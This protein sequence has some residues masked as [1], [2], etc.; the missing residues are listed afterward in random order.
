MAKILTELSLKIS[1]DVAELRTK[2]AQVN[3]SLTSLQSTTASMGDK[4]MSTFKA[5][6]GAMVAAFAVQKLISFGEECMRL[7]AKVEGVQNAFVKMGGSTKILDDLKAATRGALDDSDLMAFAVKANSFHIPMSVLVTDLTVATAQAIKLGKPIKDFAE[8]TVNSLGAG[9]RG[10]RALKELGFNIT[11]VS[12]SLKETGTSAEFFKSKLADALTVVDTSQVKLDRV[13]ANVQNLKEAWGQYLLKS[14]AINNALIGTATTL[15]R[16]ADPRLNFWEKLMWS[17]KKYEEWRKAYGEHGISDPTARA[18][19][20]PGYDRLAKGTASPDPVVIKEVTN[21]IEYYTKKISENE[22]A[23]KSLDSVI[24][25]GL[26]ISLEKENE[27]FEKN[28]KTI[29]EYSAT[30]DM[31]KSKLDYKNNPLKPISGGTIPT[32]GSAN[33]TAPGLQQPGM[34]L[35]GE[36]IKGADAIQ[37]YLIALNAAK[38]AQEQFDAAERKTNMYLKIGEQATNGLANAFE[39]LFK[40]GK[41]GWKELGQQMI[42]FFEAMI[43]KVLAAIVVWTILDEVSGGGAAGINAATGKGPGAF[44]KFLMKAFGYSGGTD[45]SQGGLSLVGER[46]PEIVNLPRG[47]QVF[48]NSQSRGLMSG[49]ITVTG[50]LVGRGDTVVAIIKNQQ[51]TQNTFA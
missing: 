46:G 31:V 17:G 21:S 29:K 48:S 19:M 27:G 12:K 45:F 33:P 28:I 25:K 13:T 39:I 4:M 5:I 35:G 9:S 38:K 26:I 49:N 30:A 23:I 36:W 34:M 11:E 37:T 18:L 40:D 41:K 47:S 16:L 1:A 20:Q 7:A 42:T 50:E 32:F 51:R 14:D 44:G 6:G 3:T 24:D 22:T 10:A 2:L 43:A 15:E 8:T